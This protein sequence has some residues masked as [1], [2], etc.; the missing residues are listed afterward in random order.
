M[1]LVATYPLPAAIGEGWGMCH[2]ATHLYVSNGSPTIF[3]VDPATFTVVSTIKIGGNLLN[4]N[5]LEMVNNT[6]IYAN[7]FTYNNIYKIDKVTGT[8]LASWNMYNLY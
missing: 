8:V 2:D 1:T 4:I 5:E 3:V 7:Q 6:Y